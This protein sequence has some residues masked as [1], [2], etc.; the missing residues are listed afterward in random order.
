MT[1]TNVVCITGTEDAIGWT[2]KVNAEINALKDMD[3]DVVDVE[4]STC[5]RGIDICYT[6]LIMIG[7]RHDTGPR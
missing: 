7:E 4:L 1:V 2:R 6:A 5:L 3:L